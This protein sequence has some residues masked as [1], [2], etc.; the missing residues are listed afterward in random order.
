MFTTCSRENLKL[1]FKLVLRTRNTTIAM[2]KERLKFVC[3]NGTINQ[4]DQLFK[5]NLDWETSTA[6]IYALP[7][8]KS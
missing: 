3:T 2:V 1:A 8:S 4:L 6:I 5:N 7:T